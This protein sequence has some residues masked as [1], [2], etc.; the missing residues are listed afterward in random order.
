MKRKPASAKYR[1]DI[2]RALAGATPARLT[3]G[4]GRPDGA[5]IRRALLRYGFNTKQRADLP[6]GV[7][8]VLA[9]ITPQ[10]PAGVGTG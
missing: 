6:D 7:A 8:E 2:A 10:Q 9:W 3:D 5:A 4:R 1:K